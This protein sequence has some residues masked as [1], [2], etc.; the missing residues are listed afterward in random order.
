MGKSWCLSD[1]EFPEFFKTPLTFNLS[2]N[3][4]VLTNA[5]YCPRITA[6]YEARGEKWCRAEGGHEPG[7]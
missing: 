4:N 2:V 7:M 5:R 1:G 3:V 6:H